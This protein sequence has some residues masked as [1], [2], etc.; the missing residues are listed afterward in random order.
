MAGNHIQLM[1]FIIPLLFIPLFII[2]IV[3]APPQKSTKIIPTIINARTT[4]VLDIVFIELI[5][6]P[7][8]IQIGIID[9]L[10]SYKE[11]YA[12]SIGRRDEKGTTSF[13]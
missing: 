4:G 5:S 7:I 11:I 10:L 2:V 6:Y 12:V 8:I 9:A 1:L 13:G 3:I